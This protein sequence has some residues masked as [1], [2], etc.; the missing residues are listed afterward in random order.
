MSV[1]DTDSNLRIS[2]ASVTEHGIGDPG[3]LNQVIWSIR[4]DGHETFLYSDE[5]MMGV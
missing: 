2:G 5:G 3:T 1:F 4:E